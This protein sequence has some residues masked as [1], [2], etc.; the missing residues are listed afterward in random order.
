MPPSRRCPRRDLFL[1][2]DEKMTRNGIEY[3]LKKAPYIFNAG[4]YKLFFSSKTNL[5]KFKDRKQENESQFFSFMFRHFGVPVNGGAA[6]D[7][8][9]YSKIEKR[10]FYAEIGKTVIDQPAK[11]SFKVVI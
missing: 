8:W 9:L 3:D 1:K 5:Q 7:F 6:A 10:G 11:L 4:D 2:E